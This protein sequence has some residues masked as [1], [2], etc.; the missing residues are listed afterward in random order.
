VPSAVTALLEASAV[1]ETTGVVAW[2]ERVPLDASGI[3]L[4]SRSKDPNDL[5]A[6]EAAPVSLA[7]CQELLDARSELRLDG[8]RPDAKLLRERITAFW[9]PDEPVLYIGLAGTSVAERVKDYY[10]TPLGARRPHSGG[11]F[12][13]ALDILPKLWVHYA[14]CKNPADAEEAALEAFAA[15]VDQETKALLHDSEQVMPFANLEYP[16]GTRKDHG[17]KGAREPKPKTDPTK[18]PVAIPAAPAAPE[19]QA[20]QQA[21]EVVPHLKTQRVTA[22]DIKRGRSASRSKARRSSHPSQNQSSLSFGARRSSA[23]GVLARDA[24]VSSASAGRS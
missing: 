12:L 1:E 13:K 8:E 10:R 23:A 21:E 20:A 24:P 22:A 18:A 16:K 15:N 19:P 11:W 9:L 14:G 6:L 7:R 5:K 17:V 2:G 4:V 3:Y